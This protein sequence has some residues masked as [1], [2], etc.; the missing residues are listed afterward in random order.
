MRVLC[1]GVVGIEVGWRRD[2]KVPRGESLVPGC[3][4]WRY[5]R[6][7]AFLTFFVLYSVC[8]LIELLFIPTYYF[9]FLDWPIELVTC[10]PVASMSYTTL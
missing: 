3:L 9:F 10:V 1:S 6:A 7:L 5:M 2:L 4:R 8:I